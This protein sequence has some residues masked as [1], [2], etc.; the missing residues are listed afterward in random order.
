MKKQLAAAAALGVGFAV[1]AATWM[2][3][4]GND[5]NNAGNWDTMPLDVDL[6]INTA[7]GCPVID[8]NQ[9]FT[10]ANIFLASGAGSSGRVDHLA[11]IA[12]TG[13][14]GWMWIGDV[15]GRGVY[16]LADATG[17]GGR[18]TELAEGSGSLYV[19]GTTRDGTL[20]IGVNGT[21]ILNVNTSGSIDA[22]DIELGNNGAGSG[23]INLDNGFINVV[24]NLEVGGDRWANAQGANYFNI[25]GGRVHVG[26]ELWI[27]GWG[28][29]TA[30][31]SG[32]DILTEGWFV[33]GR[34]G[35]GTYTLEEG[36]LS[37]AN[38]VVGAFATLGSFAGSQGTLNVS[39]GT[40]QTGE[41]RKMLIGE[42]GEGIVVISG[43]GHVI[44]NNN[45]IGSGFR[46]GAL[47]RGRGTVHL[48]G[49]VLEVP[50]IAQGDGT[51]EF[52]F[53]GGTLKVAD[54][55]DG[56]NNLM[57]GL[58]HAYVKPGGAILDTNGKDVA[59]GQALLDGSGGGGL[60]K[61]GEGVL[62][63][64][65]V[66]TY[67]GDTEINEGVLALTGV[68]AGNVN[69]ASGAS[70]RGS[71]T[72]GGDLKLASGTTLEF[73][74]AGS[75][76]V[77][78]TV[79]V[80]SGFGVDDLGVSEWENVENGTYTV[81]DG[82]VDMSAVENVGAKNAYSISRHRCAYFADGGLQLVV[83]RKAAGVGMLGFFSVG[84]LL[85]PFFVREKSA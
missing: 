37:V 6:Y 32:G 65:G 36:T 8:A 39:G 60:T 70:V 67:T 59:L 64:Q 24:Q 51:G 14:G 42:G 68:V 3:T 62:T 31:Q 46:L 50:Y 26:N 1:H 45:E 18:Y 43:T 38:S 85:I 78:G 83:D 54:A 63:L 55:H 15:G 74:P 22:N 79:L 25:S 23:T 77:N 19:G 49:G 56:S 2:G 61:L 13:D 75:L 66:N 21:G 58:D 29:G 16:N 73:S 28:T 80:D 27:G 41:G 53:N 47:A 5:W 10:P 57:V 20:F 7:Q 40:L 12:R 17:E 48:N 84:L 82:F 72:V 52:N 35:V 81:V 69:V 30:R 4:S 9:T 34:N 76:S 71:G 44:V 11:G 33:V